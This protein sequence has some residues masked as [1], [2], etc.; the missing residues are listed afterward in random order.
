MRVKKRGIDDQVSVASEVIPSLEEVVLSVR[1][2]KV[3][4]NCSEEQLAWHRILMATEIRR[5]LLKFGMREGRERVRMLCSRPVLGMSFLNRDLTDDELAV[6]KKVLGY[7][8]DR[9]GRII[10]RA[11]KHPLRGFDGSGG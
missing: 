10:G 9:G 3:T 8:F 4:S 2:D 11:D 6:C 5:L 1:V 7:E